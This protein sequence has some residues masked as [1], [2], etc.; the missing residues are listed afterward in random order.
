MS[1]APIESTPT[2]GDKKSAW[3]KRTWV[4]GV[5][6]GL[7]GIGIGAAGAGG[8]VK[9]SPEYKSVAAGLKS[10]RADLSTAERQVA[11]IDDRQKKLDGLESDLAGIKTQLDKDI[12]AVK[13][14]EV[15]VGIVEKKVAANTIDGEGIYKVGEDIKAGTYKTEGTPGCYY[16]ILRSTSTSDIADNNNVDGPAFLTVRKGQY[17]ELSGCDV[18]VRQ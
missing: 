17:L 12:E 7:I 10:T 16:A 1:E 8:S 3:Y 18:W 9:D 5:V 2:P 11:A 13:A 4:V 6:A 15:A 14:R